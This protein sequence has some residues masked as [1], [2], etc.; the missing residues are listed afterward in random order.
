MERERIVDEK[1]KMEEIEKSEVRI[2]SEDM[3]KIG[4]E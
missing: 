2:K 3:Q 4:G 1:T